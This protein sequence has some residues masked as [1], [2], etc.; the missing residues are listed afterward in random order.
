MMLRS[1]LALHDVGHDAERSRRVYLSDGLEQAPAHV[2]SPR[3]P[4]HSLVYERGALVPKGPWRPPSMTELDVITRGLD[5]TPGSSVAVLPIP[6]W[7]YDRFNEVRI[8]VDVLS[9]WDQANEYVS[10]APVVEAARDWAIG[11]AEDPD[12]RIWQAGIRANPP[13]L[14]TVTVDNRTQRLVGLHTDNWFGAPMDRRGAS[15][16]RIALNLG[17]KDRFFDYINLP[18]SVVWQVANQTEDLSMAALT[19]DLLTRFLAVAPGYPVTRVRVAPG[20]AYIA[21][22][23]NMIHD[24]STECSHQWDVY[25][26]VVGHFPI[27]SRTG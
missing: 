22:T 19:S 17:N 14:K 15:P 26:T 6:K 24:G 25:F 27:P 5:S 8:G 12:K 23:D 13:G 20:E 2:T 21:P 18:L 11:Q 4:D 1:G 7:L 9:D 16:N 10:R 3:H